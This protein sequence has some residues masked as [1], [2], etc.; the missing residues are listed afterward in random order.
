MDLFGKVVEDY[1]ENTTDGDNLLAEYDYYGKLVANELHKDFN[2]NNGETIYF[3]VN[4]IQPKLITIEKF[5]EKGDIRS[6]IMSYIVLTRNLMNH[7]NIEYTPINNNNVKETGEKSPVYGTIK[8][9]K[10]VK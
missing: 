7:Y 8:V 1:L 3:I 4:T 5:I 2:R 10:R 6:A 9:L